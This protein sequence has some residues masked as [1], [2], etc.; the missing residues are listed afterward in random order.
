MFFGCY[1]FSC[2]RSRNTSWNTS[3]SGHCNCYGHTAKRPAF[4]TQSREAPSSPFPTSSLQSTPNPSPIAAAAAADDDD[5][6]PTP[7]I[8]RTRAP[9][10]PPPAPFRRRRLRP[11]LVPLVLPLQPPRRQLYVKPYSLPP[12][13]VQPSAMQFKTDASGC[14]FFSGSIHRSR[15]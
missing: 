7:A 4:V 12:F 9:A 5:G 10:P 3:W 13:S 6:K 8:C 11:R 15:R 2:Y 14:V 1:P